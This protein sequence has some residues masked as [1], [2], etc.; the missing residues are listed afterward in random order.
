MRSIPRSISFGLVFGLALVLGAQLVGSGLAH[1][2]D[3]E[4]G[5]RAKDFKA[6][7]VQVAGLQAQ[8]AF[9]RAREE[10]LTTY[11]LANE[12]RA[13]GIDRIVKATRQ[14]GFENKSIPAESRVTLLA[15][16]EALAASLRDGIPAHSKDEA[17]MLREL[18]RL[19]TK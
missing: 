19:D 17:R 12:G 18:Q 15:G 5:V 6:L 14:Q 8:V 11:L 13:D 10:S 16:F 9:L 7:Q 1:G 2:D 3:E 4:A